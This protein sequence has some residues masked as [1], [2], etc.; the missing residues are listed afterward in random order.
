M[1]QDDKLNYKEIPTKASLWSDKDDISWLVFAQDAEISREDMIE[2]ISMST[3]NHNGVESLKVL[4]DIRGIESFSLEAR[5]YA[6][7]AHLKDIYSCMALVASTPATKLLGNFFVRFHKPPR[8]TK[9]FD[10]VE[11]AKNWLMNFKE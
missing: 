5:Q 6:A 4:V 2:I 10:T 9:I 3:R 1:E 7:S 11:E 8:P